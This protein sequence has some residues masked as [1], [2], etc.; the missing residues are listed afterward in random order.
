MKRLLALVALCLS[1]SSS[2][3]AQTRFGLG[4]RDYALA[5]IWLQTNCLAPEAAPL[6]ARLRERSAVMQRA[7]AAAVEEGPT[8]AEVAVVREAAV[9]RYRRQREVAADPIVRES[10]PAETMRSLLATTEA[11]FVSSEVDNYISGY[12]SNAMSGLAVVGDDAAIQRMTRLAQEPGQPLS[13][14]AQAALLY[15]AAIG[16]ARPTGR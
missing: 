6:I 10:I 11:A 15:R 2:T 7:F 14:A 1:C 13:K 9:A 4:E 8:N 3:W 12:R 16:E 5:A